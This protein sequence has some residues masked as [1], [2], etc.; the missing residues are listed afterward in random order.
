M[1]NVVVVVQYFSTCAAVPLLRRRDAGGL[2]GRKIVLGLLV[3]L[4]GAIGSLGLFAAAE[5]EEWI[6]AAAMLLAG[7]VVAR[8][9][10]R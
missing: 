5:K 4:L 10:A 7:V 1:T 9:S 2:A 6:F 3:P 8:V